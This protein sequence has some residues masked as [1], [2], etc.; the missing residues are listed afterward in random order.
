VLEMQRAD[1]HCMPV[2]HVPTLHIEKLLSTPVK[3]K[4]RRDLK[5]VKKT[6]K[7]TS[8][9]NVNCWSSAVRSHRSG[10]KNFVVPS[11]RVSPLDTDNS[12]WRGLRDSRIQRHNWSDGLLIASTQVA[13]NDFLSGESRV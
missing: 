4:V 6:L 5:T 1:E 8:E 10:S 9:W 12:R 3:I 13:M 7:I 2:Q 11:I